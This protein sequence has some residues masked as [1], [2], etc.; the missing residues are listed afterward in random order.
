MNWY[1]AEDGQQ[2]GPVSEAELAALVQNGKV[3]ANTLVWQQ[4]MANWLPYGQIKPISLPPAIDKVQMP[5]A[6]SAAS[7]QGGPICCECGGS[8]APDQVI[9]YGDKFVCGG[10]KPIFVQRLAE[11]APLGAAGIVW[12][13]EQDLLERDYR[14]ELED[15][16][17]RAWKL[18]TGHVGVILV[19][20]AIMAVVLAVGWLVSVLISLAV[21]FANVLLNMIFV[22]PIAGGYMWLFL[23]LARNE[24]A[25]VGDA[26]A[27]FG[28]RFVQLALSSLI[29][30]LLNI[31]CMLPL[32]IAMATLGFTARSRGGL[33]FPEVGWLLAVFA[34]LVLVGIAA[35]VYMNNL[36]TFSLLLVIDKRQ[37]VW[38]AM[39]LSRKVV[40]KRWWMT[41]LFLFVAGL[42]SGLGVVL[43]LVGLLLTVPI[44]YAM[45]ICLYEDNFHDL[46]PRED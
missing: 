14:I 18:V 6:S 13:N 19:A 15:C 46:A 11:G 27:G 32:G 12:V 1:Y 16:L 5:N 41:L 33:P 30:G 38:P 26:F 44:Y 24:A 4:G 28:S 29:Q 25:S 8:F 17:G 3:T 31:A 10:C 22:G 7:M 20:T 36:W 37:S 34:L 35:I 40:S 9:R 39:Q 2:R 42:L 21:P 43:C 45:K 23:R